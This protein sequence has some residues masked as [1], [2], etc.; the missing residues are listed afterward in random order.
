MEY[1][2]RGILIGGVAI[3][4][5]A[6]ALFTQGTTTH[7]LPISIAGVLKKFSLICDGNRN[8]MA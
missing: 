8:C 3:V 2:R 6:A 5:T 7:A 1:A 4:A